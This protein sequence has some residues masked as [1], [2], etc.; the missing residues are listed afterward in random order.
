MK[1]TH[2][3]AALVV[4]VDIFSIIHLSILCILEAIKVNFLSTSCLFVI[5]ATC[6]QVMNKD[7]RLTTILTFGADRANPIP[8]LNKSSIIYLSKVLFLIICRQYKN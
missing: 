7:V 6:L 8:F 1:R 4:F 5:V 3:A 2:I